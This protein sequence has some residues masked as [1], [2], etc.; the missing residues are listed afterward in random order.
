MDGSLNPIDRTLQTV[1]PTVMVP[2]HEAFVPLTTP[3]HRFLAAEDGLWIEIHRPWLYVRVPLATQDRVA[4]PYGKLGHHVELGCGKIKWQP[5]IDF[6]RDAA[7]TPHTEIAGGI[8]WNAATNAWRYER[9]VEISASGSH[10]NY[11]RPRLGEQEHLVVDMHSHGQHAAGFSGT[12]DQDDRGE[13]KI[14]L[15][16]GKIDEQGENPALA[17]R[18]CALGIYLPVDLGGLM[19][20]A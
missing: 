8:I 12:D 13:V 7:A 3:G 19:E 17:T 2:R 15:V 11:E 9:F 1:T 20:E 6:L 10:I 4:M 18:L 14:A 16:V 5:L